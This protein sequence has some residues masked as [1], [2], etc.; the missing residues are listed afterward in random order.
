M[1]GI[2]YMPNT[3]NSD[4]PTGVTFVFTVKGRSSPDCLSKIKPILNPLC[5]R[6]FSYSADIIYE[7]KYLYL[8]VFNYV[9]N[10][11]LCEYKIQG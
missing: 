2:L 11:S 3:V 5:L 10:S 1:H 9:M 6:V 4:D 7:Y 8:F